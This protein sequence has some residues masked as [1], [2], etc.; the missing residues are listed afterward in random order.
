MPQGAEISNFGKS[1]LAFRGSL[2]RSYDLYVILSLKK[3]INKIASEL[4]LVSRIMMIAKMGV[5]GGEE[6][7]VSTSG[8]RIVA[9]EKTPMQKRFES[10][11]S[12][13]RSEQDCLGK[14]PEAISD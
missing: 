6:P 2:K 14:K 10:W 9:L 4:D 12:Q 13:T 7:L 1:T 11:L 8:N 3:S 5:Y